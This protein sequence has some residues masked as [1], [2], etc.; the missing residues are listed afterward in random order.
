M[1]A[2]IV[3][4]LMLIVPTLFGIMVINFVVVQFAPGGPVEQ[5]IAQLSGTVVGATARIG[6]TS[7]AEVGTGGLA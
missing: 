4:R 5:V 6:G 2:Y 3:R 7:G 1:Y